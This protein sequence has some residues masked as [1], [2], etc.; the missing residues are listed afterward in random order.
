M[1]RLCQT[2]I[3]SLAVA[4]TDLRSVD[5]R[6]VVWLWG[7][8]SKKHTDM[9]RLMY[10]CCVQTG[11]IY[12]SMCDA[13]SGVQDERHTVQ[14][15]C[16]FN[17]LKL[18]LIG[19]DKAKLEEAVVLGCTLFKLL[20]SGRNR[21]YICIELFFVLLLIYWLHIF[22]N[23]AFFLHI[24]ISNCVMRNLIQLITWIIT[25]FIFLSLKDK[26]TFLVSHHLALIRWEEMQKT[27]F[28]FTYCV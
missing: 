1:I 26:K 13:Q 27:L 16:S 7:R 28:T 3:V 20:W 15:N 14:V 10:R 17:H 22:I 25:L 21:F 23:I 4:F 9:S 5:I 18:W 19:F 11:K 6:N 12:C 2:V 24:W 8:V